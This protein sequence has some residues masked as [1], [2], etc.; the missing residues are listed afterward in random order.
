M[1]AVMLTALVLLVKLSTQCMIN[2]ESMHDLLSGTL[3][4]MQTDWHVLDVRYFHRS[5]QIM[6]YESG[7]KKGSFGIYSAGSIGQVLVDNTGAV[8]YVVDGETRY[9][10]QKA[11]VYP[12]NV[13]V[14]FHDEGAEF[15][16]IKW[17]GFSD[18][19]RLA[20]GEPIA[21][22]NFHGVGS[23]RPGVLRKIAG[24]GNGWN[25]GAVSKYAITAEDAQNGISGVSIK[26]K[27]NNK[28]AMLGLSKGSAS[29][30]Y[31][32]IDYAMSE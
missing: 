7:A 14:S 29:N 17:V 27:Q 10:S 8:Q 18:S 15:E 9:T 19:S 31:T 4:R 1:G 5:G 16:D 12:L 2:Q 13:D 22:T 25:S 23:R 20:V 30:S 6:V 32:D 3:L 28:Y 24:G 21:F 26:A 11:P